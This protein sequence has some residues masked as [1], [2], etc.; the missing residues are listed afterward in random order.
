MKIVIP[1]LA[2]IATLLTACHTTPA[3]TD[4]LCHITGTANERFEGKKI[5]LVPVDGPATMETVDS[6][7]ITDGKFAF[8]S[9]P[10]EMKSIRID[11]RHRMH[12][13]DLL[14]VMEPGQVE[15]VIDTISSAQGTPMNDTLQLWKE[16]TM[17]YHRSLNPLHRQRQAAEQAGDQTTAASLKA[18]MER[19]GKA[20]R[21]DSRNLADRLKEGTLFEFLDS[22]F[23]RSYPK[24]MPDG[25]I[26]TVH[27]KY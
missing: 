23:P 22:R 25:T 26:T 11:F 4:G 15:V 7:V 10:G 1:F 21:K 18:E 8:A 17:Q 16:R 3:K 5:F 6:V 12:V 27:V 9:E 14:L 20:Y 19:L 24:K 2:A 13:E